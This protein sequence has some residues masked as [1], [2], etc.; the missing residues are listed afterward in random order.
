[1]P[2]Q[3][4]ITVSLFLLLSIQRHPTDF[5]NVHTILI[6]LIVENL[7]QFNFWFDEELNQYALRQAVDF[8][9]FLVHGQMKPSAAPADDEYLIVLVGDEAVVFGWAG[10]L[11]FE[12]GEVGDLSYF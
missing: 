9:H 2:I 5:L 7:L 3:R 4:S 10:D 6:L 11:W 12:E 1:M 8:G